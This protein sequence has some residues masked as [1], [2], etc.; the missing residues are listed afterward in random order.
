MN[1]RRIPYFLILPALL[2]I[3]PIAN[4]QTIVLQRTFIEQYK[5]RA[6]IDGTFIVDKAHPHPNSPA[7]DGDLH[8]AGRSIDVGL[9]MVAEV[10]NAAGTSQA[11]V[12]RAIHANQGKETAVPI[13]GAW[14]IWFEHPSKQPQIQFDDVPPAGN[15]NPDHCFE[16]H[17]ITAYAGK[18]ILQSL[19]E[20]NGF[21]PKDA[22]SA[23]GRYEKLSASLEIDDQTVTITSKQVGFNYVKFVAQLAGKPDS[24]DNNNAGTTDGQV[25]LAN[26]M[27][28]AGDAVLVNNVR[29]VFIAGTGP[30]QA[31]T[32]SPDGATLELLALPRLDLNAISTFIDA[33]GSGSVVRKLPYEMIVVGAKNADNTP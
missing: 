17:P 13:S 25:V 4:A 18:P 31:L 24:L 3:A 10:M 7:S 27:D 19:H 11:D 22:E 26:V 2:F 23:F 5:N 28:N 6:T 20:I 30:A 12:V 1:S 14:R 33:G 15:T 32:N 29:L 21:T 8:A 16:I 9:P